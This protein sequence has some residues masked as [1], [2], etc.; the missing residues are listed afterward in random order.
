MSAISRSFNKC[1]NLK[2]ASA[3]MNPIN[4]KDGILS[5]YSAVVPSV[6]IN[7]KSSD[8]TSFLGFECLT[9]GLDRLDGILDYN[10]ATLNG[11]HKYN[12][13]VINNTIN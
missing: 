5:L 4:Y 1:L 10:W 8:E 12:D 6:D 11:E 2:L 13:D 3:L 7:V 9:G